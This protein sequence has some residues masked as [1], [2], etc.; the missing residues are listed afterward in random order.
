M[1]KKIKF[2]KL[3]K[4]TVS[5]REGLQSEF[6]DNHNKK[7]F[8][9][10]SG[11]IIVNSDTINPFDITRIP[12]SKY[13]IANAVIGKLFPQ[14]NVEKIKKEILI[15]RTK[16]FEID[17]NNKEQ[18]FDILSKLS[19]LHQ[20]N[21]TIILI[22]QELMN[23]FN[24]VAVE[25]KEVTRLSK[26]EIFELMV[27]DNS[28]KTGALKTVTVTKNDKEHKLISCVIMNTD[29]VASLL[30]DDIEESDIDNIYQ[31][32]Y[33]FD[34]KI[35]SLDIK[36]DDIVYS[37]L[38]STK[39]K[40][41]KIKNL[42]KE[43]YFVSETKMVNELFQELRKSKKQIAI[44]LA[45]AGYDVTVHELRHTFATILIQNNVDFK[46]A[47]KLLGHDVEQ[48][49]NTYSHVNDEMLERAKNVIQKFF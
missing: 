48:T 27:Y 45:K 30:Y 22:L 17:L 46:T 13:Q 15:E 6:Y 32:G 4:K 18:K 44:V 49:M 11:F 1:M 12:Y 2:N 38:L 5:S 41:S 35:K 42:V 23:P 31:E 16:K 47:A 9:N 39:N 21:E 20:E 3:K 25:Q 29:I 26:E 40:N 36:D 7:V 33:C 8:E 43:A 28:L 14:E 24:T 34:A 19:S 10:A 37:I